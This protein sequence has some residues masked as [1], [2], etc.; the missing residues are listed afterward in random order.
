[1]MGK[2]HAA[3]AAV[4]WLAGWAW[5]SLAGLATP[6]LDVLAIGG[7]ICAGAGLLPDVDHP[8]STIAHTAGRTTKAIAHTFGFLGRVVHATTKLEADRPDEDGHRTITHTIAFAVTA[9]LVV[10]VVAAQ[11]DDLGAWIAARTGI[12]LL[13]A[14]G[15]LLTAGLVYALVQ[16]GA[17]ALRRNL[18]GRR[19]K[20]KLWGKGRNSRRV[21][22][23]TVV[24]LSAALAAYAMVPGDVWWLGLAVGCGCFIHL[25]GDV[26]TASGAPILWPLP[27]PRTEL[28][29]DRKARRKV[30]VRRWRTW[31]LIGTPAW[32]RFR[33]GSST[34][35]AV[36]RTVIGFG[37]LMVLVLAYAQIWGPHAA[38]G[39][40]GRGSASSGTSPSPAVQPHPREAAPRTSPS[41]PAAVRRSGRG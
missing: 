13:A 23:S 1:M 15:K 4:G 36:T 21:H 20:V 18:R 30:P 19:Q 33:V 2:G 22:K 8:E 7:L 27:I 39:G 10:H 24:A 9:G 3:S 31:Y 17:A 37:A 14:L 35:T 40:Y 32:M 16:L 5:T 11:C 12:P 6:H 38:G 34:E 25:L 26:V 29:Y 41:F 28:R